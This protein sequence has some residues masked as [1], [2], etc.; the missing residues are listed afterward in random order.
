MC[1]K[2]IHSKGTDNS[3]NARVQSEA[4]TQTVLSF[5]MRVWGVGGGGR[6]QRTL[7]QRTLRR[8]ALAM[9]VQNNGPGLKKTSLYASR[10]AALLPG[11]QNIY[12]TLMRI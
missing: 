9:P 5:V 8:G 7:S 2:R 11:D 12:R 1:R 3:T 10:A 6:S 4:C